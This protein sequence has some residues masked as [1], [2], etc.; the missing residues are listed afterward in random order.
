MQVTQATAEME[1]LVTVQESPPARVLLDIKVTGARL[2]PRWIGVR[3]SPVPPTVSA[4]C[5][6]ILLSAPV[7]LGSPD[8]Q[9][10]AATL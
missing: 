1:A 5:Q 2:Y 3:G 8:N 4:R 10:Q 7:L 9:R 6:E